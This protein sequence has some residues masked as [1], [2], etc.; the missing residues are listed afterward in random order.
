MTKT[1]KNKI[2][3]HG[4]EAPENLLA[5][6]GNWRIHPQAQQ[7]A[8]E[9][10]IGDIGFIRSVT[11]NQ[12][13][14]HV[15]DGHLRVALAIRS[16]QKAI[17]VEY[18]DLTPAEE[19]EALATIDPLSA[20]AAT[21]S[22]KLDELL[23][24]VSSDNADVMAMLDNLAQKAGIVPEDG[25]APVDLVPEQFMVLIECQNEQEQVALLQ[26]LQSEGH[27]CRALIS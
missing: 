9:G 8:L 7:A 15:I 18:V 13:T 24:E 26:K 12:Q 19:A 17:P 20:L 21:D 11:V 1:W 16:G 23:R 6:P 25:A 4:E 2:I 22:Q 10:V 14:G 5:H 27:Q 3:G